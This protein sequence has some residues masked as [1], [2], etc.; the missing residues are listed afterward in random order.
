MPG[1]AQAWALLAYLGRELQAIC[2]AA[3]AWSSFSKASSRGQALH[4]SVSRDVAHD[5]QSCAAR[6]L[7]K[8]IC[9]LLVVG[10]GW[11]AARKVADPHIALQEDRERLASSMCLGIANAIAH[12]D[13]DV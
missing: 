5:I 13:V 1:D 11:N 7:L 12:W 9:T 2:P 6:A 10:K 3:A 8:V 4:L